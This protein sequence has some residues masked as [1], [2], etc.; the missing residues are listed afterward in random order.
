MRE[1]GQ[2]RDPGSAFLEGQMLRLAGHL[3]LASS[4]SAPHAAI[5]RDWIG[6]TRD[7]EAALAERVARADREVDAA[8][9]ALGRGFS[10]GRILSAYGLS[11]LE[12]DLL[13]FALLPEQDDRF[14]DTFAAMRSSTSARR[15]TLGIALRALFSAH[16][17]RWLARRHLEGSALWEAGLFRPAALVGPEGHATNPERTGMDSVLWPS[18]PVI[19]AAF[20]H[21][22]ARLDGG[23]EI[24]V[25]AA[26]RVEA[27]LRT[28][29]RDLVRELGSWVE[30]T[31]AG[32]V[33]L[34]CDNL[35]DG[36][37]LAKALAGTFERPL[38]SVIGAPSAPEIALQ[39]ATQCAFVAEGL[40]AMELDGDA[41]RVPASLRLPGP[42]V[43][44]T[45]PRTEVRLP[46]GLPS[47][48]V[49][50]PRARPIEQVALWRSVLPRAA[51][52]VNLDVLANRTTLSAR[53]IHQI[54]AR[55]IDQAKA[56]KSEVTRDDLIAAIAAAVPDPSSPL[57]R[58]GR[59]SI[60]WT[61]LVLDRETRGQLDD[62]V[63][64]IEHRVTVQDT[65][66]MRGSEGRGEGLVA[67]FHGE[68][69]T[70]KTLAA[71]AIA[72]R[73]GLS[74]WRVDL[75]RVVSKYIG[76]TE[77]QLSSLFDSAEGFRALL[78]FDEADTLFSKRTGVRDAHDRYANLETNYMLSRLEAFEGLAILAT[79]FLQNIDSAFMRRL[80]FIVP[81]P[82]PTAAQRQRLWMAHLPKERLAGD[83]DLEAIARRHELTGGEIR[84]AALSA[85]FAAA[86]ATSE[87]Q[88]AQIEQAIVAERIK[89]GKAIQR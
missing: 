77:K 83:V 4:P 25:T 22:P 75:S 48:R 19:A 7:F 18:A 76:E 73:L 68:P 88:A 43:I 65:W 8:L 34:V 44:A 15:P 24:A 50:V 33:H 17:D 10:F 87:I 52:D 38:L 64:R 2:Q 84:S 11:R 67:M 42:I 81:F 54:G 40:V 82:R 12:A 46:V 35:E 41:L 36:I 29:L 55:A 61:R 51:E 58:A 1:S 66:G 20:G 63:T 60:P 62:L 6:E 23:A 30:T 21:L 86:A 85:A 14:G 3:L 27:P 56:R 69:G 80:S 49:Y 45:P 13:C 53:Q 89:S 74:L 39:Q 71:E 26:T 16:A 79:N 32:V 72:A 31:Q 37:D 28:G 57:A 9:A 59:P 5:V 47:R 78:F 70:G